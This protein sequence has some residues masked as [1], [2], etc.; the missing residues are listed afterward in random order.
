[1]AMDEWP[2]PC[3][4][5][6]GQCP[7]GVGPDGLETIASLDCLSITPSLSSAQHPTYSLVAVVTELVVASKSQENPKARA[8]REEDLSSSIHPHLKHSR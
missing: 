3:D 8:E 6:E 1:M 7:H 4:A 2:R 5:P